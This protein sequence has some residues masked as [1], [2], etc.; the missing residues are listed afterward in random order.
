MQRDLHKTFEQFVSM[1]AMEKEDA[2]NDVDKVA[3]TTLHSAKGLEFPVVFIIG[4]NEDILP[5]VHEIDGPNDIS[6]ERRLFY[7][8]IT[9]S[10]KK[11]YLTYAR[12]KGLS[13]VQLAPSQFLEDLP[14]HLIDLH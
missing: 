4:L 6:E 13:E 8:G 7:V 3:L 10:E 12:H 9:R 1:V 2:D 5:H 14:D 11:L